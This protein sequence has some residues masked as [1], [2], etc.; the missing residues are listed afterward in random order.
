MMKWCGI[1]Y[2]CTHTEHDKFTAMSHATTTEEQGLHSINSVISNIEQGQL[3]WWYYLINKFVHPSG[4]VKKNSEKKFAQQ[5][6][7]SHTA[8]AVTL[9]V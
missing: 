2:K 5:R 3:T 1:N 8:S 7:F 6:I 9:S 4:N